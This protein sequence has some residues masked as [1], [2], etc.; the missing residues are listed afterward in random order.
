MPAADA[1]C[2]RDTLRIG[3][4]L[5]G[6]GCACSG[7]TAAEDRST[8]RPGTSTCEPSAPG[9]QASE[10]AAPHNFVNVPPASKWAYGP[11]PP[12]VPVSV[13]TGK[14]PTSRPH[15]HPVSPRI[16]SATGPPNR[17]DLRCGPSGGDGPTPEAAVGAASRSNETRTARPCPAAYIPAPSSPP[18]R[19]RDPRALSLESV[20]GSLPPGP[21]AA[22]ARDANPPATARED[23]G[24]PEG[25][26]G[27]AMSTAAGSAAA[28]VG[29][30]A[31]VMATIVPVPTCPL[32]R[33]ITYPR[34]YT[35]KAR[36][37]QGVPWGLGQ[38]PPGT[39]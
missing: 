25:H 22:T 34:E 5:T 19:E 21:S 2:G 16:G 27:Y 28:P 32:P 8:G 9:G 38:R 39:D 12:T 37:P 13:A 35:L 4:P 7:R 26:V 18:T 29:S 15:P 1:W 17:G 24:G 30:P 10:V 31:E 14:G 11:H 6:S 36:V 33:P 3:V 23:P 20:N